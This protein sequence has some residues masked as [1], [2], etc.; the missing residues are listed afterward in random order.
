MCVKRSRVLLPQHTHEI[1]CRTSSAV[2]DDKCSQIFLRERGLERKYGKFKERESWRKW[3]ILQP[4]TGINWVL[5]FWGIKS[6]Q[7]A[8]GS[9]GKSV[10][11]R[12]DSS[13]KTTTH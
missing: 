7:L 12:C 1:D 4:V 10:H 5:V 3:I 9:A 8:M 13:R 6:R 2:D 11:I